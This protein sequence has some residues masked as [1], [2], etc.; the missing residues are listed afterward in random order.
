M[1]SRVLFLISSLS[2]GGAERQLVNLVSGLDR[3]RWTA[4]VLCTHDKGELSAELERIG[5]SVVGLNTR[6]G[7]QVGLVVAL[8]R[9]IRRWRPDLMHAYLVSP[10]FYSL[11]LRPATR[12]IPLVLG[13]RSS[14][15][16]VSHYGFRTALLYGAV[17]RMR[18][19]ADAYIVNSFSGAELHSADGLDAQRTSI[20]PNG[21]SIREFHPNRDRAA[22]ARQELGCRCDDRH[23]VAVVATLE[24][25]KGHG[26]FVDAA[27]T[28]ARACPGTR[29]VLI[30]RDSTP[31][32]ISIKDLVV[33]RGLAD[34]FSFAGHRD[35]VADLLNGVDVVCSSSIGEGFSNAVAE[36]MAMEIPCVVSDVGDSSRIVGDTGW[37]VPPRD[38]VRLADSLIEALTLPIESLRE[39]GRRAR[40]RIVHAFSIESMVRQTEAVYERL[41]GRPAEDLAAS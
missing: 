40:Q 32:G 2:P 34:R 38:S 22:W 6:S 36:A 18:G 41:V 10:Q 16:D 27:A 7:G 25:M 3:N 37:V 24:H 23:V 1:R 26:I 9:E 35:D 30:G 21:I 31:V 11:L 29:F 13:I 14:F 15:V 17:K 4:R 28:V 39:R 33:S 5:V 12:R 19:L 8:I 20:I